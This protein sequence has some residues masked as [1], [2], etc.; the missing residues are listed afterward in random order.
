MS[1]KK[2]QAEIPTLADYAVAKRRAAR[3]AECVV[4]AL[5]DELRGQLKD[6][7]RKKINVETAWEYIAKFYGVKIRESQWV[8]HGNGHHDREDGIGDVE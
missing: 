3:K 7:R 2:T 5:P 6:M 4:C 1:G 8:A